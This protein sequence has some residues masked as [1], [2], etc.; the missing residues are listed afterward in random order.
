MGEAAGDNRGERIYNMKA[1]IQRVSRASVSV[2]GE[3]KGKI[4]HG[5]L[6]FFGVESGDT[7]ER[8]MWIADKLARLRIFSD[9]NGKMNLSVTDIGG[10][11][12]VISQFT[13]CADCRKGTRPSFDSAE[14]PDKANA[15]YESFAAYLGEKGIKVE[16]GVFGADMKVELLNDGPVTVMLER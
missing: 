11:I 1:L 12:L 8:M 16:T 15:M 4:G 6:V 10:E 3:V 9:E 5:L 14:K 13:L 7:E 2:D